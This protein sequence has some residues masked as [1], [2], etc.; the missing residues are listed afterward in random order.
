MSENGEDRHRRCH[1]PDSSIKKEDRFA[2]SDRGVELESRK[3]KSSAAKSSVGKLRIK[4][5]LPDRMTSKK[6]RVEEE[7]VCTLCRKGFRSKKAL[8]GH[9]RVHAQ[10]STDHEL[11][12][13][14]VDRAADSSETDDDDIEKDE[15]DM[16]RS[17]ELNAV[18]RDR[19]PIC[20]I[21]KKDF[22]SKKAL[23]GHMRCHPE[24]KWRGIQPPVYSS[25]STVSD[26]QARSS[27]GVIDQE[28]EEDQENG[29]DQHYHEATMESKKNAVD[30]EKELLKSGWGAKAMRGREATTVKSSCAADH[31]FG[32]S[33]NI[34]PDQAAGVQCLI[35]LSRGCVDHNNNSTTVR[36]STKKLKFC[37]SE[38]AESRG[39]KRK[40]S[41]VLTA[42][43]L[44]SGLTNSANKKF[45]FANNE[46]GAAGIENMIESDPLQLTVRPPD[47]YNASAELMQTD[48]TT[49][50][51]HKV[52][53]YLMDDDLKAM[54][55]YNLPVKPTDGHQVNVLEV[56]SEKERYKCTTCNKSFS[57][58]QALG[59]HK[60]SHNKLIRNAQGANHIINSS[61]DAAA[62]MTP[63]LAAA[64]PIH[65]LH[66][67]N[68]C[69]KI[70]PTGQAL[71]GHKRMHC[72]LLVISKAPPPPS[73]PSV[74]HPEPK[75]APPLSPPAAPKA[76]AS[77]GN[78]HER[79]LLDLN[80]MP[81]AED[82]ED[83]IAVVSQA[84][85]ISAA[86]S[87]QEAGD[88][89]HLPTSD[90]PSSV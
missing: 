57:S 78:V 4:I 86:E 63:N 3:S 43:E 72:S 9:M 14:G 79:C 49:K 56:V 32:K 11:K 39:R 52:R 13:T 80:E 6:D 26:V 82:D 19:K 53:K 10:R 68:V 8:G 41:E 33:N 18:V 84:V 36:D 61:L 59:G 73:P 76:Q 16:R 74:L 7:H 47:G 37:G 45:K 29:H 44:V 38:L 51:M 35:L 17:D 69:F 89:V 71:G 81:P 31:Q 12:T 42:E 70:Y 58:H 77:A 90:P 22:P 21:C 55:T 83:Q 46:E 15:E 27:G 87:K 50:K 48:S 54:S 28:E 62:A 60:S 1:V 88:D 66:Q 25:S 67:C 40:I 30:L 23:F 34:A 64:T 20:P 5:V 75:A 85:D 2:E 24:R 65:P